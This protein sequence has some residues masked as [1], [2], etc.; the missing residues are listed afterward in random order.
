MLV[1]GKLLIIK[2]FCPGFYHIFEVFPIFFELIF[3]LFPLRNIA[4]KS[5]GSH[6]SAVL[7]YYGTADFD[8]DYSTIFQDQFQFVNSFPL[9][10]DLG[11]N[12]FHG[13]IEIIRGHKTV[14]PHADYFTHIVA[15]HLFCN[16]V[17]R[18]NFAIK[19]DCDNQIGSVVKELAISVLTFE[20]SHFRFFALCD[21]CKN[22]NR[23]DYF[24][25]SKDR[26]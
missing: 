18:R 13:F 16:F 12:H 3:D 19:A 26:V 10:S 15:G 25:F 4:D 1:H 8:I 5:L 20:Q 21:I 24:P 6:R 9:S 17:C 22:S 2:F 14:K 23:T 11:L 7:E